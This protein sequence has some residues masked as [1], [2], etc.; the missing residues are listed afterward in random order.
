MHSREELIEQFKAYLERRH[1][2]RRTAKDYIS[3]IRQFATQCN[4]TWLDITMHDI[5]Q[6]VDNQRAKGLSPAT[7]KRRVASLKVFFD[8]VAEETEHLSW[9]NPVRFKRYAGQQPKRLPRDL[10]DDQLAQLWV[11]INSARDR[12]WFVL[13]LRAGVRVGE[14]VGLELADL[15]RPPDLSQPA[16]LRVRGK[17]QKERIVLLSGEA[18][19]VLKEWLDSRPTCDQQTIFLNRRQRPLSVAGIEWLLKQYGQK[20]GFKVTPHQLRHTFARQV[21]ENGMPITSLSKLLGHNQITTTQIYTA[22]A[23]PQLARAYQQ[24]MTQLETSQPA[25]E[26]PPPDPPSVSETQLAPA[27]QPDWDNWATDLP[28]PIRQATIA[29]VKRRWPTWKVSRRR[30][31]AMELLGRCRRFWQWQA[32]QRPI[33]HP[34]ELRLSDLQAYQLAQI[35][36]GKATSTINRVLEHITALLKGLAEQDEP[37]DPALFRLPR[38]PRPKSLPRHLSQTDTLRLEAFIRARFDNSEPLIRL[39]N[40]CFFLLAHTG[41]RTGECVELL[42]QDLDLPPK[43]LWIRQGK[44]Q[45]DRLVYLSQTAALALSLYLTEQHLKPTQPLLQHPRGS[46]IGY[47]WLYRHIVALGRAAGDIAVTPHQLRHT[48]ATRLLNVGLDITRIQK[49]LGHKHL[50]TTQIYAHL[51]DRTLEKDY[52][53]AMKLIE[54]QQ[55]SM[56]SSPELVTNWPMPHPQEIDIHVE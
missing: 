53:Q 26:V 39:E 8:F 34:T 45:R 22:G 18:Y 14:L 49:L 7:I 3:D 46:Q 54:Q 17:G 15:L 29:F 56:S 30:E 2:E 27:V 32:A 13:M 36:A 21:T 42:R 4:K 35:E 37:V 55:M 6:F 20:A 50:T 10:T 16:K 23:D 51:L 11:Q 43:R 28:D 40:A 25:P 19:Q 41:I 9:P 12:A 52:Q 47:Q 44:G 31:W 1:P 33:S 24:A 5:D 38:L 48:F